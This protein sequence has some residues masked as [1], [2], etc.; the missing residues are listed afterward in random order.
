MTFTVEVLIKGKEEVV[1]K[2]IDFDGP[3]AGAWTDE[4]ARHVLELTLRTFDEVQN[5]DTQDRSVSLRGF[6]WIVTPVSEGVVVAIEIPSGAVVAGPFNA[7]VDMLT[8]IIT[9]A[10]ANTQSPERVH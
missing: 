2:K 8:A 5:P 4:D 7:D 6:S 10:L 9:R 3:E 1:E